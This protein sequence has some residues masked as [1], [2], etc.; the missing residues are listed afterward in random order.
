MRLRSKTRCSPSWDSRRGSIRYQMISWIR[1]RM[2][3]FKRPSPVIIC[4]HQIEW[5][6]CQ[7]TISSPWIQRAPSLNNS[8]RFKNRPRVSQTTFGNHFSEKIR[9]HLQLWSLV[10]LDSRWSKSRVRWRPTLTIATWQR[11]LHSTRS[12]SFSQRT[13]LHWVGPWN[14]NWSN[15]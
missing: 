5:F 15:R 2:S 6:R 11:W 8:L 13:G 9:P 4:A 3:C 1:N 7:R 12:S 10:S 14:K